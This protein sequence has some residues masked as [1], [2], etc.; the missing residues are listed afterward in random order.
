M[1]VDTFGVAV[2][3]LPL[4]SVTCQTTAHREPLLQTP[5]ILFGNETLTPSS[6]AIETAF[7]C[8][9]P[10]ESIHIIKYTTR[11]K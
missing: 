9:N 1:I 3:G 6:L 2:S 8:L 7:W 4:Q 11:P 10:F 5:S